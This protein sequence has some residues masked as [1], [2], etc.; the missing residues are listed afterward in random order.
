[1]IDGSFNNGKK[2]NIR[3]NN[4]DSDRHEKSLSKIERLFLFIVVY[5]YFEASTSFSEVVL[6]C[7]SPSFPV[8][9]KS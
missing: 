3:V 5:I 4:N 8:F 1:M 2:L 9:R 6:P 7:T